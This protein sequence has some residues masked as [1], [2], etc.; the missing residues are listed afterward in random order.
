MAATATTTASRF[1]TWRDAL[2]LKKQE[3]FADLV[4]LVALDMPVESIAEAL[5]S[6]P[7]LVWMVKTNSADEKQAVEAPTE[8]RATRKDNMDAKI[9]LLHHLNRFES[10]TTTKNDLPLFVALKGANKSAIPVAVPIYQ[11]LGKTQ[12][13]APNW[14]TLISLDSEEK[15]L[16]SLRNYA[17]G[18]SSSHN[19]M[20]T[21]HVRHAQVL[22]PF[23]RKALLGFQQSDNATA[24]SKNDA[25]NDAN[26]YS[27]ADLLVQAVKAILLF[28]ADGSKLRR[29][30]Q[31]RFCQGIVAYLWNSAAHQPTNNSHCANIETTPLLQISSGS[32]TTQNDKTTKRVLKWSQNLHQLTIQQRDP[33]MPKATTEAAATTTITVGTENS[34]KRP[35]STSPVV[36]PADKREVATA[37]KNVH[38]GAVAPSNDTADTMADNDENAD[39]AVTGEEGNSGGT[40]TIKLPPK[41]KRLSWDENFNM[42]AQWV[43]EQGHCHPRY[44]SD[45]PL[46]R[47]LGDWVRKQKI[48]E[49]SLTEEQKARLTAIGF[50]WGK[51]Q[52]DYDAKWDECFDRLKLYHDTYNSFRIRASVDSELKEW[53]TR[54]RDAVRANR[55]R[56]DRKAKLES[57]DFDFAPNGPRKID[58]EKLK[59][60]DQQWQILFQRLVKFKQK[61]QHTMIPK[62]EDDEL[63]TF[64]KDQ[65]ALYVTNLLEDEK[66]KKLEAIDFQWDYREDMWMRSFQRYMKDK[67]DQS[68]GT[69]SFYWAAQQRRDRKDKRLKP[70]RAATLDAIGFNWTTASGPKP[71]AHKTPANSDTPP[72]TRAKIAPLGEARWMRNFNRYN[73]CKDDKN[74]SREVYKWVMEQR[75]READGKLNP[76]FKNLLE[77]VGFKFRPDPPSISK[78]V[79]HGELYW[80]Q[81]LDQL[82]EFSS[83]HGNLRM[84]ATGPTKTLYKWTQRQRLKQANGTLEPSRKALLDELGFDFDKKRRKPRSEKGM[85]ISAA[86]KSKDKASSSNKEEDESNDKEDGDDEG[87]SEGEEK[88]HGQK[89]KNPNARGKIVKKRHRSATSQVT[90]VSISIMCIMICSIHCMAYSGKHRNSFF[91]RLH[92]PILPMLYSGTDASRAGY[93]STVAFSK[94]PEPTTSPWKYSHESGNDADDSAMSSSSLLLE[95]LD[96]SDEDLLLACRAYLQ[97][98]NRLGEWT[99]FERRKQSRERQQ[100]LAKGSQTGFFWDDPAELTY[101]NKQPL[102]VQPQQLL[103]KNK[104]LE[105]EEQAYNDTSLARKDISVKGSEHEKN[106]KDD[107]MDGESTATISDATAIDSVDDTEL[108]RSNSADRPTESVKSPPSDK[109]TNMA[110]A[111]FRSHTNPLDE[112]LDYSETTLDNSGATGSLFAAF[113]VG[114]NEEARV[115]LSSRGFTTFPVDPS[116]SRVRRSKAARRRWEDPDWKAQWYERRW[117]SPQ[118]RGRRILKTKKKR[119]TSAL[120][121]AF[122][123]SKEFLALTEEEI[124]QAVQMYSTANQK[125]ALSHR[126]ALRQR[127]DTLQAFESDWTAGNSAASSVPGNV[128]SPFLPSRVPV[129]AL[130]WDRD[131]KALEEARQLRAERAQKAY[132]T[133]LKNQERKNRSNEGGSSTPAQSQGEKQPKKKRTNE[134][135]NP[136]GETPRD[137]IFRIEY[138][139]DLGKLPTPDDIMLIAQPT[140]LPK[141]RQLLR[142][143]LLDHFDL[144]GK[145]V[146]TGRDGKLEFITTCSLPELSAFTLQK[147]QEAADA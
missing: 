130:A 71:V 40:A 9:C 103:E 79:R 101:Y 126:Q 16:A 124:A 105:Q 13:Q 90:G 38:A 87:K 2:S 1:D 15:V 62:G 96:L 41:G 4:G 7:T 129:D 22:P 113:N 82:K 104:P 97:K 112:S 89:R 122:L 66:K 48:K 67:D 55:M 51:K 139:L 5:V 125:R 100:T 29:G 95:E 69:D 17:T 30:P 42:M 8:P 3:D 46:E 20:C 111:T 24:T 102:Q 106:G 78:A 33:P 99:E 36:A 50:E 19:N 128:A 61:H 136:A 11:A 32:T 119:D 63:R 115:D 123:S 39:T 73:Q 109:P 26:Y 25:D 141:R 54:Q 58:K 85:K 23:L 121:M 146:P 56:A 118:E 91:W 43:K 110:S 60:K 83:L 107:D 74:V 114:D 120:T 21:Y 27:P 98:K 47:R 142:K 45:D 18:P 116:Q 28:D 134:M 31:G 127:E 10:A 75:Q 49:A 92:R 117:G 138:D 86:P 35:L 37:N 80:Y 70:S 12:I 108:I 135:P 68:A 143:I 88:E 6:E 137:A 132:Q 14:K 131:P 94:E 76:T 59:E 93:R 145:C 34:K 57:I 140:R 81:Q 72:T 84:P 64:L 133:R 77:S 44:A 147:V 53:V 144:R 52:N 65:R